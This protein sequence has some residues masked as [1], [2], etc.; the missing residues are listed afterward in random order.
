MKVPPLQAASD[1]GLR[2]SGPVSASGNP[3][4]FSAPDLARA[5][6]L[7]FGPAFLSVVAAVRANRLGFAQ[8]TRMLQRSACRHAPCAGL[9]EK[10]ADFL[11]PLR[12]Q[13]STPAQP[14]GNCFNAQ[15]LRNVE[16]AKKAG[17][18]PAFCTMAWG[19]KDQPM[20]SE[21]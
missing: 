19:G 18:D 4:C 12:L 17:T 11:T 3:V 14:R 1:R 9:P 20:R 16:N 21:A 10:R 5:A 6:S 7:F 15:A 8:S 13:T 2:V